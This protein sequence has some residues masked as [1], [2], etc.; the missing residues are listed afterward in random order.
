MECKERE[1]GPYI[2]GKHMAKH[3]GY[4]RESCLSESDISYLPW[5]GEPYQTLSYRL[6]CKIHFGKEVCWCKLMLQCIGL[7][8]LLPT[9]WIGTRNY[10][11][12]NLKTSVWLLQSRSI[13]ASV[14]FPK[15]DQCTVHC[16]SPTTWWLRYKLLFPHRVPTA[17]LYG[18]A[19]DPLVFKSCSYPTGAPVVSLLW[20]M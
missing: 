18:W 4:Y 1:C 19:K 11:C 14:S 13:I 9:F 5:R 10:Q 7:Y 3:G 2:Q 20:G 8:H 6:D 17:A 12:S 15:P 16:N